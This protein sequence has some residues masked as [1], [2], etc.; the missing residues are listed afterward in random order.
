MNKQKKIRC[1]A[2]VFLGICGLLSLCSAAHALEAPTGSSFGIIRIITQPEAQSEMPA[3]RFDHER[4]VSRLGEE[5]GE[6]IVCHTALGKEVVSSQDRPFSVVSAGIKD[7]EG[8]K[9]AWHKTCFDCHEKYGEAPEPSA[10]RTCHDAGADR[11][12]RLTV[13]F[14]RS[15]HAAHINS[16]HIAPVMPAKVESSIVTVKNCGACHST[17]GPDGKLSYVQNTEDAASFYKVDSTDSLVLASAAHNACVSCHR[18]T[19]AAESA[20]GRKLELPLLCADCHSREGQSAFPKDNPSFRL[21]RGQPDVILLG[22][23]AADAPVSQSSSPEAALK[24]VPFNH[25]LHEESSDCRVCHGMKIEKSGVQPATLAGADAVGVE[26]TAYEAAHDI[27]SASSCVGCHART[28]AQD[29]N[30]A[31][32]HDGISFAV[33]DSCSVCHRGAEERVVVDAADPGAFPVFLKPVRK[34]S[35]PIPPEDVPEKVVIGSLSQE[36]QPVE[37][38]HRKIYESLLKGM[39]ENEL[40]AS[41]HVE[42]VCK[43][44]HHKIPGDNIENPPSCSSCHDKTIK[45]VAAGTLPHLKAAYHQMC[46]RCHNNMDVKPSASDCAG[47][48]APVDGRDS[49]TSKREVR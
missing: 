34:T 40:A 24:A 13:H 22:E 28:V 7:K 14:D 11:E 26:R 4:H 25:K 16:K 32:C 10:C 46:I 47:C 8:L 1:S 42:S 31:G 21:L 19:M 33:K 5:G 48:H 35:S 12:E 45:S 9:E 23:K 44:C 18:E 2:T 41:F 17:V 49:N 36:Y 30:C 6:C 27:D 29:K 15:L 43:A 38:P 39:E 3:A 20:K 37:L